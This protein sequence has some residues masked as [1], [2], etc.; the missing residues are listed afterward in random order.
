MIV[1]KLN[2]KPADIEEFV[3]TEEMLKDLEERFRK[4]HPNWKMTRKEF[5]ALIYPIGTILSFYKRRN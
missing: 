2:Q 5:C 1:T 3:V 4:R